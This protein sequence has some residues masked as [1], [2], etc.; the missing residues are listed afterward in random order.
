MKRNIHFATS[1]K[2]NS[3]GYIVMALAS[4]T[5][6]GL[7]ALINKVGVSLNLQLSRYFQLERMAQS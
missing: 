4:E 3:S 5:F 6:P 7:Q 2:L 1:I